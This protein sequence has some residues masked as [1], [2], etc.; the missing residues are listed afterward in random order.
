VRKDVELLGDEVTVVLLGDRH[1]KPPYGL[2]G[3]EPGSLARTV[4]IRG[5]VETDLGSKEVKRLQ[6]GDIVSFRLA[7]AGGYGPAAERSRG[8]VRADLL[9]GYITPDEAKSRYGAT[10]GEFDP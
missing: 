1:G 6:R 4:L 3:G 9:D 8:S 2:F 10:P 5:G 7:G